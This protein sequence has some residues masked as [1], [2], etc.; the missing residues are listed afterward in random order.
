MCVI[1]FAYKMPGLGHLVVLANRDEKYARP[2]A[3]LDFWPDRPDILGG[4]DLQAG[5]SWMA[6]NSN[7]RFAA[8]THIREGFGKPGERSR[9]ELVSRFVTGQ[10]PSLD[11]LRWVQAEK[12]HY[13]PFNLLFGEV[14]DLYHYH[15]ST[16]QLTRV[17]PGIHT[18]SNATL[19]TPWFKCE[20]LAQHLVNLRRMPGDADAYT[21]L[22][23]TTQAPQERLPNTGIG[24][25]FERQ[26]SPI[27]I[28]A[29]D[30]G[31]L[32]SMLLYVS[33]RGDVAFAERSFGLAGREIGRRR[34]T[35][36]PGQSA[37]DA[38]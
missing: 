1:A 6:I 9:G 20:R 12:A 14:D 3:P 13:A 36:R 28:N 34:Y 16:G 33:A 18:L 37:P 35:M 11:F 32:S 29:R 7:S 4:R 21:W 22:E 19:D 25:V 15:S 38:R 2:A 31:T 10:E 5:G 8:V 26:L 24:S 30:Y 27:F 17:T 23:D